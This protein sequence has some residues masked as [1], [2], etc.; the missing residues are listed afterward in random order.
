MKKMVFAEWVIE[1]G[2]K[3]VLT[4]WMMKSGR[5]IEKG[6]QII[7]DT[8][9]ADLRMR[10]PEHEM[11][12]WWQETKMKHAAVKSPLQVFSGRKCDKL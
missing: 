6:K 4:E 9:T 5:N 8:T 1:S 12:Q 3:M 10:R 2:G 7:I 11:S